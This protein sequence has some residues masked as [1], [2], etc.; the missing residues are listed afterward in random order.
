MI[1][2]ELNEQLNAFELHLDRAGIESLI[3]QLESLKNVDSHLHL[4]TPS[5]GGRE[6]AEKAHGSNKLMNRLIIYS[7]QA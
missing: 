7:H 4:M 2:A 1:T 5:W 6:L 3:A